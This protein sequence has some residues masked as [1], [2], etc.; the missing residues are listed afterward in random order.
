MRL[1]QSIFGLDD[2]AGG[3][4]E[5]LIE[6]AT[7]RAVECTD[8]RL[9]FLPGYRKRLRRPIVQAIDQVVALVDAIPSPRSTGASARSDD[10]V[11]SALF[12]SADAMRDT[13]ARDAALTD[14]LATA[15]GAGTEQVHALLLTER[16]ERNILGM[17]LVGEQVRRDV[18]Q[19]AVSFTAHRLLDPSA[20]EAET[21][22]QLR[23]RA[24]D[25]LLTLALGRIAG[26]RT[27]RAELM[28]QRDLLR[29]KLVALE[30]AGWSFERPES[31]HPDRAA[32]ETELDDITAQLEALGA[33]QGVLAAHL[34]IL[35]ELLTDAPRQLWADRL[36]LFLDPMNI[37]REPNDPTARRIELWELTNSAGR[38]AVMVPLTI[39]PRDL[40]ERE[41]LVTAA[42][43]YLR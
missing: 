20:S 13:F 32:L 14:F 34:D 3:Y 37:Q 31:A 36:T 12:A 18:P 41:D 7:E 40:P 42:E 8:A 15:D 39:T 6:L 43:R 5:S 4:P 25:H 19:V 23:R 16:V 30:Q 2:S 28:R 22:R 21:R 1:F 38:R 10:P 17:D 27:E 26:A 33:E 24:F 29:R 35:A 9:R 11:L